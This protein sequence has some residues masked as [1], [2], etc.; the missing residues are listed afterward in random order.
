[1]RGRSR[2]RR[3][4]SVAASIA[5]VVG[6]FWYFLPQFATITDVWSSIRAM[7]WPQVVVLLAVALWNVASYCLVLVHSLPGLTF[8][9]AF[10]V[11]QSSTAVSNTLPGG[12]AVGIGLAYGMYTSWGFSRSRATVSVLV[13]GIWTNFG[14]LGTPVLALAL[15]ALEGRH[16]LAR[17]V[18]GLLGI[19]GLA[20]A[21]G[22]FALML[23]GE[24]TARRAGQAAARVVA[25][26]FRLLHRPPPSGWE[27]A[28]VS[29]RDRTI[30][31]L[32]TRWHWLTAATVVSQASL[33]ALLLLSLRY[34][35]VGAGVGDG[36]V[37]WV[38][39]LAVFAFAR[40]VTAVPFTP[41]GLGIVEIALIAGLTAAGGAG[42][43]VAA[44]VLMYRALSHVLPIPLGV[45]TYVYWRRSTRWRRP[46]GAAPRP[47]P[48][49]V[50]VP[51]QTVS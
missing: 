19:V 26:L 22:V 49:P 34:V 7:T 35:G 14:K 20:G 36:A 40:L 5:I 24:T 17:L 44:G 51:E 13:S 4:L 11:T 42:A 31:L 9:Q 27:R 37:G 29:F 41:G 47:V 48:V 21:V 33:F 25:P 16:S 28:T 45:V 10:V 30:L 46:A 2:A 6:V 1:V 43:P 12:S 3:P 23:R 50:P 8:G 38:E 15:L 32:R 39:V 18:A